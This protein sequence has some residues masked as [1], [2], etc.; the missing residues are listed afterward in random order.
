MAS[1]CKVKFV[2]EFISKI[3]KVSIYL[4]NY[5]IIVLQLLFLLL[6]KPATITTD[7]NEMQRLDCY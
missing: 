1:L 7:G 2:N 6:S 3:L 4:N 5:Y